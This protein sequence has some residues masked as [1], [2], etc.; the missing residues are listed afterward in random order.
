MTGPR[1]GVNLLWLVPGVVGGSEEYTVRT[2][3][4]LDDVAGSDL[5]V[6]LFALEPFAAAHPEL[7]QRF[8]VVTVP[9]SGRRKSVR[10][11]AESTWL[12]REAR[13]QHLDLI[14]HAGGIMPL[15]NPR[16]AMLTIHDVQ[17]LVYPE[18]FSLA[19]RLFSRFTIPRSARAARLVVAPSEYSRQMIIDLLDVTPDRVRVVPPGVP[20]PAPPPPQAEDQARLEKLGVRSP[21]LLYPAITYAHKNHRVL[22][23]AFAV[24]RRRHRDLALVL[25]GGAGPEEQALAAL[26]ARLGLG[27]AVHRLG[28]VGRDDLDACI[29]QASVLTFPSSYEGFGLPVVEAMASG[30]PVVAANATALPEVVADAGIL[31]DPDDLDGWVEAISTVLD[32]PDRR[33]GLVAA[34]AARWRQFDQEAAGRSLAGAYRDAT[35]GDDAA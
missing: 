9:L 8:P 28:R 26:V 15:V 5:E 22:I 16:P 14:H 1:V 34:G 10:V 29:R 4:G 3:R 32:D 21:F 17:P 18:R 20:E 25:T 13:R 30:L 23:R 2:L 12:A 31:V 27:G 19:K 7:V 33:E 24:L 6:T 11:A 35:S